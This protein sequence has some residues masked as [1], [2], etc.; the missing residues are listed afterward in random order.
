MN[1]D[2]DFFN[3]FSRTY[4]P[5]TTHTNRILDKH[6]LSSSYWR[7]MRILDKVESR[8]FGDIT[9]ELYIE[10]PA[11]TKII[12]K[13]CA[14]NIVEIRLGQDKREKIVMLTD[15]GKE[16][17]EEIRKELYPFLSHVVDDVSQEELDNVKK[18]LHM[19]QKNIMTY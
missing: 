4:R 16:K 7:V 9:N 10:K 19:I 3:E 5:I 18:V 15:S 2:V 1:V 6:G 8:N 14:M 13:L 17:M 12:K 11:L